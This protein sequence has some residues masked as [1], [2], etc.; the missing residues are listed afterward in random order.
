[1]PALRIN[2]YNEGH[3]DGLELLLLEMSHELFG[4]AMCDVDMFVRGHWSVYVVTHCDVPV[5]LIAFDY[6]P[7]FGLR[8]P[9]I[10]ISYIYVNY[11]Y[12]KSSVT[13]L[14][15]QTV[16]DVVKH[17]G[18]DAEATMMTPEA[19]HLISQLNPKKVA[20]VWTFSNTTAKNMLPVLNSYSN[21]EAR[22]WLA[23]APK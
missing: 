13:Q 14:L 11:S 22:Q 16:L 21:K 12:R 1:M 6:H 9:V 19:K 3:R 2:P 10:N 4:K 5:G 7:Y 18:M 20:E 23:E 17:S 15:G 8:E